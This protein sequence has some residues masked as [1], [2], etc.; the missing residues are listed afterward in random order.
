MTR[1]AI[2]ISHANP[3][4]N[5]FARWLGAKLAAMGFEVWADVMRLKGGADWARLLEDALRNRSVKVLVVCTPAAM[6]KQGVRNE[7]EI[8][9]QLARELNDKEFLIPLRLKPYQPHLRIAH[10]QY[11]D[12]SRGWAEG[13]LELSDLLI[14]IQRLPREHGRPMLDWLTSQS[15]GATRLISEEESLVSN[16]LSFQSLPTHIYYSEPPSG[17]PLEKFQRREVHQWPIV[18]IG[19]GLI[20]YAEPGPDGYIA[21]DIPAK[22]LDTLPIETFMSCG[23]ERLGITDF[24]A[25]RHFSDLSNQAFEKFL[26][27]RGLVAVEGASGSRSWWGTTKVVPEKKIR[28]KWERQAG[29]RQI[30]GHSK[31]RNV[32]WHFAVGAQVRTW[33]IEHVRLFPRLVFSENGLDPIDNVRRAHQ[34]RRSFAKSWRNAR[35]RDMLLAYLWWLSEGRSRIAL[36]VSPTRYVVLS[37]PTMIFSCP[38]KVQHLV[39]DSQD[40]DD[41]DVNEEELDEEGLLSEPDE[42]SHE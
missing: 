22:R 32:S 28:F 1:E 26:Q 5:V 7:I 27:G 3:E 16:W 36:L 42:E 17:F 15:D 33:P 8:G 23:W 14:N 40:D 13:L 20:S 41:P 11:I 12:F 35:W 9:D 21:P 4:D 24:E 39:E 38:V 18:P 30:T 37:L 19:N 2:F 6:E 10:A 29:L 34:L 25:K 31:K